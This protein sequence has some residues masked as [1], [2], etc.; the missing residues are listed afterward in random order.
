MHKNFS[1][2][3]KETFDLMCDLAR[4]DYAL[5]EGVT[6]KDLEANLRKRINE[7]MLGGLS[8]YQAWRRNKLDIFEMVEEVV[9]IAVGED[10]LDSAFVNEFVEVKNRGLG[11][12]TAF[13]SEGGL[14]MVTTFA[15]N[16]WD[17]D[18]QALDAGEEI[19]LPKEWAFIHVY[20]EFERFLLGITTLEKMTD[21]I[22]KSFNK[23]FS[24]RLYK[25]FQL[26]AASVPAQFAIN[27]NS[28]DAVGGLVDLVQA[29]GGYDSI[30]IAGTKGALRKLAA[31]VPDKMFASSQKEAK[32]ND[33]SIGMW[34]GNKLMVIPQVLK[35]GAYEVALDD[36][37]LFIIGGDTK[38][39]KFEYYGDTRTDEDFTGGHRHADAT[40]DIQIQTKFGMGLALSEYF[41]VFTFGN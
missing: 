23:F 11:D 18:R 31:I 19:V 21:K 3:A 5:A 16:H 39:I 36:T 4:N 27:G 6:K 35:A 9:N 41:G 14:L 1:V 40:V 30:T 12:N 13:Y 33:G 25:Q 2:E 29:Y 34:E 8:L 20:E 17:T 22:Y 37:K 7:D 15:G 32:A 26:A 28:E 10:I 38:P 24:E